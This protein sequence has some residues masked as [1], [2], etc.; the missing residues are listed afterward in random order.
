MADKEMPVVLEATVPQYADSSRP[1]GDV[2][3]PYSDRS[4]AS[5]VPQPIPP[6]HQH[7]R[8][9]SSNVT[10][11]VASAVLVSPAG[12][13]ETDISWGRGAP[14]PTSVI[15]SR[16][17]HLVEEG[18]TEEEIRRLEEEERQLDA[19]IE[20]AGRRGHNHNHSS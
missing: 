8:T 9:T 10:S 11:A 1:S 17:A 2:Y 7:H 18:M 12:A 5:P 6:Q 13:S 15:A 19:A 4:T 16:Y 20:N 3:A 14:T